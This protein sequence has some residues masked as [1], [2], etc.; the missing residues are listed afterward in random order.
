M[1]AAPGPNL[2]VQTYQNVSAGSSALF[3]CTLSLGTPAAS[4][5]WFWNA[6]YV[7]NASATVNSNYVPNANANA[8]GGALAVSSVGAADAGVFECVAENAAGLAV[9]TFRLLVTTQAPV[10]LGGLANAVANVGYTVFFT[11]RFSGL[12]PPAVT[13]LLG[14]AN[15]NV[16]NSSRASVSS[17]GTGAASYANTLTITSVQLADAGLYTCLIRNALGNVSSSATLTV[18]GVNSTAVSTTAIPFYQEAWFLALV[19]GLGLLLLLVVLGTML[20]VALCVARAKRKRKRRERREEDFGAVPANFDFHYDAELHGSHSSR[21]SRSSQRA[22]ANGNGNGNG[23]QRSLSNRSDCRFA[24]GDD[25]QR[26]SGEHVRPVDVPFA[27]ERA[28]AYRD[29]YRRRRHYGERRDSIVS[30]SISL[31]E[32]P[33]GPVRLYGSGSRR[34]RSSGRQQRQNRSSGRRTHSAPSM[35]SDSDSASER[36]S[37]SSFPRPSHAAAAIARSRLNGGGNGE[38]RGFVAI[39]PP[40]IFSAPAP[41]PGENFSSSSNNTPRGSL[42]GARP[43][44]L[45]LANAGLS[46]PYGTP[47][48]SFRRPRPAGSVRGMTNDGFALDADA[49]GAY[50]ADRNDLNELNRVEAVAVAPT[51]SIMPPTRRPPVLNSHSYTG[52]VLVPNANADAMAMRANPGAPQSTQRPPPYPP[53]PVPPRVP[54]QPQPQPQYQYQHPAPTSTSD[55]PEQHT[56]ST[57]IQRFQPNAQ[58]LMPAPAPAPATAAAPGVFPA[59]NPSSATGPLGS[60]QM[61][62]MP[63][64]DSGA[65][66]WPDLRQQPP[67][68]FPPA[69]AQVQQPSGSARRPSVRSVKQTRELRLSGAGSLA[70][71]SASAAPGFHAIQPPRVS[72]LAAAAA[73]GQQ[74]QSLP[75]PL[76]ALNQSVRGSM[77]ELHQDEGGPG[78]IFPPSVGNSTFV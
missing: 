24:R 46:I 53:P 60:M 13:W 11:C 71:T 18:G 63:L 72:A 41:S 27:I 69:Q 68:P 43:R 47:R 28:A 61:Q 55:L 31:D 1:I 56:Y 74:S 5:E 48:S 36:H 39:P 67:P 16:S 34:S 58:L 9:Q 42:R 51:R 38:P 17:A 57:K 50:V 40:D 78:Q 59:Q 29:S 37:L 4:I 65:Q 70:F 45:Q 25:E 52:L 6:Q 7:A 8:S 64:A 35:A 32:I 21:R 3:N 76:L 75:L 33:S 10:L 66:Y 19:L 2:G 26:E 77:R 49:D 14:A 20:L 30:S 12:P 62:P 44:P 23:H 73:A 22:V 15:V 54:H